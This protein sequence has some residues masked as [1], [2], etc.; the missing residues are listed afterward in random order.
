MVFTNPVVGFSCTKLYQCFSGFCQPKALSGTTQP[1][2]SSYLGKLRAVRR[3]IVC[4]ADAWIGLP[5]FLGIFAIAHPSSVLLRCLCVSTAQECLS[6]GPES[7]PR[8]GVL[9]KDGA[10]ASQSLWEGRTLTWTAA[11]HRHSWPGGIYTDH[12]FV[13]FPPL[14]APFHP[15]SS[16]C[17][18]EDGAQLSP[19]AGS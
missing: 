16:P 14:A 9:G 18:D 10:S 8:N 3:V 2:V 7:C 17:T 15:C 6:Q 19:A 13:I 5:R 12:S 4:S 1:P 11:A